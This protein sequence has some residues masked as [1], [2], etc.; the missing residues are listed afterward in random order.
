MSFTR[1]EPKDP[2]L[3]GTESDGEGSL[4]EI[5]HQ[6]SKTDVKNSLR[7]LN[8]F[9]QTNDCTTKETN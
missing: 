5:I 1:L 2:V 7:T 6:P 4:E 3:S 8:L 9:L